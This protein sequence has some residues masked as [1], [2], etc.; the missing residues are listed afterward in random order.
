MKKFLFVVTISVLILVLSSCMLIKDSSKPMILNFTKSATLLSGNEIQFSAN[1]VDNGSGLSSVVF[2][3]D[4][5]ALPTTFSGTS[6]YSANWIGV[7]GSNSVT[8]F[9][10]DR[11]GNFATKTDTFFVKDSTPPIVKAFYPEEIAQNVNFP[12]TLNIYDPQSGIQ[13]VSLSVDGKSLPFPSKTLTLSFSNLGIHDLNVTAV[14]G[15]GLISTP[16]FYIDVVKKS[17]VKPYVQFINPPSVLQSGESATFTVYAY[18]P[19]G[20]QNVDFDLGAFQETLDSQASNVYTFNV[21]ASIAGG[22]IYNATCTT[23]DSFGLQQSVSH[24][25]F[26]IS[27][28]STSDVVIPPITESGTKI[29]IPFF[30]GLL[31]K[32]VS[33]SAN[34]DG[35]PLQVDGVMPQLYALWSPT[36]GEHTFNVNV[37]GSIVK[38]VKFDYDQPMTK[39]NGISVSSTA[40]SITFSN[41]V[42]FYADPVFEISNQSSTVLVNEKNISIVGNKV[43]LPSSFGLKNGN[44]KILGLRD[45]YGPMNFS[46]NLPANVF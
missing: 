18:S 22:K 35:I 12:V 45:I 24:K 40:L 3:L 41:N 11:S 34:M 28:D 14:N 31:S 46:F 5:V 43:Y 9:A 27:K 16:T 4:G 39:V 10:V 42:Y 13:S 44:V 1:V 37:N 15:Q 29:K 36:F 25:V 38:N 7:Y 33:V 32:N 17:D 30:V 2:D 8:V 21:K 6:T 23:F 26:V 19:N 20:I